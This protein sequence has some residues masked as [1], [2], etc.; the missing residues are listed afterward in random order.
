M[1]RRPAARRTATV[2]MG[3]GLLATALPGCGDS[4]PRAD[5]VTVAVTQRPWAAITRAIAGDRATVVDAGAAPGADPH[6]FEPDAR[7]AATISNAD[8][9]VLNGADLDHWAEEI[10]T[11]TDR[12]QRVVTAAEE[13]G[14]EEGVG[15]TDPHLW[16]APDGV[17]A[18]ARA[19]ADDLTAADPDG[20]ATYERGLARFL[21]EWEPVAERVT[22]VRRDVAGTPVAVTERVADRLLR[23][24]GLRIESPSGF[25]IA[26][27]EGEEPDARDT[28][29][30]NALVTSGRIGALVY[31]V[32]AETSATAQVR[33]L[34]NDA[35]VPV[36]EVTEAMPA[37][38]TSYPA[39]VGGLVGEIERA[40]RPSP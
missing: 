5:G 36:V 3:I 20:R 4:E 37:T 13:L 8:I 25:A 24:L 34:A 26:V 18:V 12:D 28:A 14:I 38:A 33:S 40:L 7:T 39:W 1:G 15:D 23:S 27:E 9:V 11:G 2:L 19:I 10:V 32:D 22:A 35:S 29:A 30:M 6:L 21:A 16:F 31:N 17:P